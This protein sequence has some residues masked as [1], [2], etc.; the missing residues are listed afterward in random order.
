MTTPYAFAPSLPNEVPVVDDGNTGDAI[1]DAFV[2][3]T[4]P[5]GPTDPTTQPA[6]QGNQ[7]S[8]APHLTGVE[9]HAP[10]GYGVAPRLTP[11]LPTDQ[12][13]VGRST[14]VAQAAAWSSGSCRA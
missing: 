13:G 2:P 11:P 1:L 3:L 4:A 10:G 12:Y 14:Q 9:T 7:Y 6:N 5:N 8:L